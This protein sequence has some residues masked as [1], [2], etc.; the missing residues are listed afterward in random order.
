MNGPMFANKFRDEI[1]KI[2]RTEDKTD[3]KT[4]A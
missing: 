2:G 4:T 1:S 3:L